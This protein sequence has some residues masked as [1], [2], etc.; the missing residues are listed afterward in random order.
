[1]LDV[2]NSV[3]FADYFVIASSQSV[4][5]FESIVEALDEGLEEDGVYPTGREG[6]PDSGWILLD[7]GDIVLH[8]FATTERAYYDLEGL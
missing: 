3:S 2:R 4:P 1:M 5:Q 7:Y 8:L 6:K